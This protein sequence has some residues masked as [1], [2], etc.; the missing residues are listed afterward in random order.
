[1]PQ[2]AVE[3]VDSSLDA[4]LLHDPGMPRR[5]GGPVPRLGGCLRGSSGHLGQCLLSL[6]PKQVDPL[7]LRVHLRLQLGDPGVPPR[8]RLGSAHRVSEHRLALHRLSRRPGYES[9]GTTRQC[10]LARGRPL[11]RACS[12]AAPSS[13]GLVHRCRDRS[14][15]QSYLSLWR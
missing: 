7:L 12:L 11:S 8:D 1:M 6:L 4:L 5:D 2:R 9:F 14:C 3:L 10:Y 15:W 13:E